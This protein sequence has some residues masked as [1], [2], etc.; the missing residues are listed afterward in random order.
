MLLLLHLQ[1]LMFLLI[2]FLFHKLTK[3]FFVI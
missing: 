1:N 2:Q 3:Y